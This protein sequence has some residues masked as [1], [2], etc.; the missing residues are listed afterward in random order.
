MNAY[1]VLRAYD[2][3]GYGEPLAVFADKDTAMRFAERE[4]ERQDLGKYDEIHVYE[5]PLLS[6]LPDVT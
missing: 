3:E 1:V 6:E 2:H 4:S 5:R